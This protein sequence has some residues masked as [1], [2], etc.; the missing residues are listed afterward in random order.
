MGR[1]GRVGNMGDTP[2][3]VVRMGGMGRVCASQ[4]RMGAVRSL[5]GAPHA[6]CAVGGSTAVPL[7]NACVH[8]QCVCDDTMPRARGPE[9]RRASE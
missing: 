6:A 5:A 2:W 7:S 3:Y 9:S 4:A 1:V 8:L